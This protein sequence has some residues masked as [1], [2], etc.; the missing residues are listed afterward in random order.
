V[1][2][3]EANRNINSAYGQIDTIDIKDRIRLIDP[4]GRVRAA[5]QEIFVHIEPHMDD[6]TETVIAY[7]L[8][9]PEIDSDISPE[10][11][12]H[13][14]HNVGKQ[15]R[16]TMQ[17][18]LTEEWVEMAAS[19]GDLSL[20]FNIPIRTMF[21]SMTSQFRYILEKLHPVYSA[22][23]V[24][25]FE[26]PY[27]IMM[28]VQ[29][30][31][32]L[33]SGRIFVRTKRAEVKR[34][35]EQSQAFESD[36]LAVVAGVNQASNEAMARAH[37]M[38]VLGQAMQM[39]SAEVATAAGQSAHSMN[40][41]ADT[42]TT[43]ATE[44]GNALDIVKES[45]NA[46][47]SAIV[48]VEQHMGSATNL[49][50]S[51]EQISSIVD[52]IREV[53]GHTNLLALNATIEAARA[54]D[55]G[56]GFSVVAQ[57]VKSLA[58]KTKQAT[59]DIAVRISE[60]QTASRNTSKSYSEISNIVRNLQQ[61]SKA[62]A[63]RLDQQGHL[64]D[65]ITQHVSETALTA[66]TTAGNIEAVSTSA[67]QV[68]QEITEIRENHSGLEAQMSSLRSATEGFLKRLTA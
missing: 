9:L 1:E 2:L 18:C 48:Q 24:K 4:D 26:W 44:I 14:K 25:A 35:A 43:L 47:D 16:L 32:E 40:E 31:V 55:A 54:G 15:M 17:S 58:S 66:D 68:A 51:S 33:A 3:T 67:K 23:P 42:S 50:S 11:R 27:A 34:I 13:F 52:I 19:M 61:T 65:V 59:D 64:L 12:E 30:Q 62:V 8:S 6:L 56:R 45:A 46:F 63:H 28:C 49:E 22:D 53:A 41:A 37:Q 29:T 38:E 5:L 57:E 60:L 21:A 20:D 7:Y 39:R 36:I 10:R